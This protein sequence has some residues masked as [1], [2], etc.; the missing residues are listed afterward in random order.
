[1]NRQKRK[2]RIVYIAETLKNIIQKVYIVLK[3]LNKVFADTIML[4]YAIT[5]LVTFGKTTATESIWVKE[6]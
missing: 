4:K 3:V 6:Q 2:T 1:M 5:I